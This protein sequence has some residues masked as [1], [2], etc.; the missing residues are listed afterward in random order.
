MTDEE[1]ANKIVVLG[2]GRPFTYYDG[3][4]QFYIIKYGKLTADKF[5]RDW[6]VAGA[7]ME[8]MPD[9]EV[10]IWQQKYEDDSPMWIVETHLTNADGR[11]ESLPRAIN[12]ACSEALS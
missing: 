4:D 2:V 10:T 1:L 3:G 6:R 9:G 5:V 7:M 8:K 12:E 11:D